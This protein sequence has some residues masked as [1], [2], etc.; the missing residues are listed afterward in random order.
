MK[1][2]KSEKLYP[3]KQTKLSSSYTAC[4]AY[5]ALCLA[6]LFSETSSVASFFLRMIFRNERSQHHQVI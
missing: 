3:L 4:S 6:R 5:A 2:E 1:L